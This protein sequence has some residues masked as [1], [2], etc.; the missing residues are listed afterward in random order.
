MICLLSPAR[1]HFIA[2]YILRAALSLSPPT[3]LLDRPPVLFPRIIRDTRS[4]ALASRVFDSR[5]SNIAER[6]V[7]RSAIKVAHLE[8]SASLN[9]GLRFIALARAR[10]H[11]AS[12]KARRHGQ[13]TRV[14]MHVRTRVASIGET[15]RLRRSFPV[16]HHGLFAVPHIMRHGAFVIE[17]IL[18]NN[19]PC[20]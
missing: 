12:C 3:R 5:A 13:N 19:R 18:I 20:P 2:V 4:E 15:R 17:P 14:R 1:E 16:S 10:R 7:L 8:L 11:A 6:D 9:P